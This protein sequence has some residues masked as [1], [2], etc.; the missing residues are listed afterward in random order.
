VA[1]GAGVLLGLWFASL[2]AWHAY[3]TWWGA[4]G[5][6]GRFQVVMLVAG[7]VIAVIAKVC[8]ASWGWTIGLAFFLPLMI[9]LAVL[10][11]ASRIVGASS[12][13][14]DGG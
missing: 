11:G 7:I 1:G 4:A 3:Q 10:W 8:G 9:L 14:F 12:R 6:M 13:T 5:G 2:W